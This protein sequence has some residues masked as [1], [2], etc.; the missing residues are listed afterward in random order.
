MERGRHQGCK[1][2]VVSASLSSHTHQN[3]DKCSSREA[4]HTHLLSEEPEEKQRNGFL[5]ILV[6]F[7][8]N[9]LNFVK[10]FRTND[11]SKSDCVNNINYE[12]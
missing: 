1:G 5:T 3:P 7:V 2:R 8:C 9:K 10:Y 4:I 12:R 6:N 11:E